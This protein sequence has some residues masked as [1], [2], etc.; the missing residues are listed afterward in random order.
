[1]RVERSIDTGGSIYDEGVGLGLVDPVMSV[2]R[3]AEEK[4][5]GECERRGRQGVG[6]STF[7]VCLQ[8]LHTSY[9]IVCVLLWI[10][11]MLLHGITQ[12]YC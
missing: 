8:L 11:H 6:Y 4:M 2:G 5:S 1:M 12:D 10:T 7:F 9:R 3:D